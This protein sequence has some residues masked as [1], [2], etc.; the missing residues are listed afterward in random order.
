MSKQSV[1][2]NSLPQNFE[3]SWHVIDTNLA[4]QT[5]HAIL[6]NS[7]DIGESVK[8]CTIKKNINNLQQLQIFSDNL[9][10]RN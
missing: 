8:R 6:Q 7:T 2:A 5:F 4:I 3:I 10:L 9:V 1:L